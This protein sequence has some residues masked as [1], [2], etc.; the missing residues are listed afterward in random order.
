M[1]HE[2]DLDQTIRPGM[3]CEV[4]PMW[5]PN[6]DEPDW[7]AYREV[8]VTAVSGNDAT[9]EIKGIEGAEHLTAPIS[10]R[11]LKPLR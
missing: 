8:L 7:V 5:T 4:R 6:G 10:I 3:L 11:R 1:I 9:I 2:K